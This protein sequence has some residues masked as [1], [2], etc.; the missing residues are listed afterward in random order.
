MADSYRPSKRAAPTG[1]LADRVTFGGDSFR[2]G[3]DGAEFT[4]SSDNRGLQFPPTA[5]SDV[6]QRGA[7]RR[8]P[9]RPD[10]PGSNRNFSRGGGNS[11]QNRGRGGA[12]FN[13]PHQRALLQSRDDTI[14]H[15]VGV[16]KSS[17]KFNLDN[18]SEDDSE[19]EMD[20]ESDDQSDDDAGGG[21]SSKRNTARVQSQTRADGD[22]VPKWCNPD[23][24][25]SLP[26]PEETTGKRVNFVKLIRKAKN[27]AA[28]E[29]A[30]GTNAVAANDDFISFGA[31]ADG[32]N[33][34][35]EDNEDVVFVGAN[36]SNHRPTSGSLNDLSR[37]PPPPPAGPSQSNN[38]RNNKRS[39]ES[40]GLP[41][42]PQNRDVRRRLADSQVGIVPS[43]RP[44]SDD[45]T[46][47]LTD[48]RYAYLQD[49]PIMWLH[50]EILDFYEWIAPQP[51]EDDIRRQLVQDIDAKF[52]R[53]QFAYDGGLEAFGSY[54]TGLY[55]PSA[56]M[57]LVYRTHRY[58]Q[59]GQQMI[60]TSTSKLHKIGRA[61]QDAGVAKNLVVIGKAKVPI[62]KFEDAR[63]GIQVDISFENL[64]G[65]DALSTV[66]R[67][68]HEYPDMIYLVSLVKQFLVMRGFNEVNT[69]GLGGFSI[70]C[71]VVSYLQHAPRPND[72]GEVLL[73]FLDHYGNKFDLATQRIVMQPPEI[74]R[75]GTWGIDGRQ[76]RADGLSIQDPNNPQNN[77]SGGS[78][79]AHVVFD[80]F[81]QAHADLTERMRQISDKEISVNSILE[82]VF[83]GD[84]RAY[85]TIRDHLRRLS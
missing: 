62:I 29:Q 28:T 2:P 25:T 35:D 47:W 5:P 27:D 17:N 21:P 71:L 37:P 13:A 75:K 11:R 54:P 78:R 59:T 12:R 70:I 7:P 30:D 53:R 15:A 34:G 22:S 61:L 50:N 55:L 39:A 24:Y 57:D 26:P 65:V 63:T 36:S 32:N 33:A 84:Y 18:L 40:A 77:I 64:S 67:W 83:G 23:P 82:P 44:R 51:K 42:R 79:K 8:L 6:N 68:V 46:P 48:N 52:D 38:K 76:E 56:D 74:K 43:W 80:L 3:R 9:N 73:G 72:V 66:K 10:A 14:E 69:G 45:C 81:A 16:S 31:D 19:A 4:Y 20:I 41:D 60:T 58:R 49:K 1:S 85:D